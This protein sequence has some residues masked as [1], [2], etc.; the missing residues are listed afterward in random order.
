MIRTYQTRLHLTVE[1]E[2]Q[3]TAYAELYGRVER[4]LFARLAAGDN[5]NHLKQSL[6]KRFGITA[7]QFNAVHSGLKGKIDSIKSRRPELIDDLARRIKRAKQVLKQVAN[8]A[9][10]HQ[11]KRRLAILEHKLAA[12][13]A[14]R[15]SGTVRLCFGSKKLFRS[16]FHLETNGYTDFSAWKRD[17]QSARSSQF[18][19]LGSKDETAGCQG[20]VA[21]VS[22][23]G[24][25]AL[26]LRLPNTAS[27]KHMRLVDLSF[28]HGHDAILAA[29]GRNLSKD[30]D[31]WQAI[32]YRF[33]RDDKGWRV[34]VSVALPEVR[35]I[36]DRR[37]GVIGIDINADH[38]AITETDRFGNPIGS[39]RIPCCTYG[40]SSEQSRAIIGEA[41]KQVIA[42]AIS[43]RK[44][45]AI[46]NLDFRKKKAS[47]EKECPKYARMLSSFAYTQIQTVIRSRAFDKGIEVIEADPTYTSIV[48]QYKYATRYGISAHQ[49]AA[50]A[51]GRNGLGFREAVP[52][53]LAGTLSLPVR[54]RDGHV[55]CSWDMVARKLKA[56]HAAHSRSGKHPRSARLE[57]CSTGSS[58]DV[59]NPSVPG[60]IPECYSSLAPFE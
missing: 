59:I 53:Q 27:A 51:I 57:L 34:F 52:S 26:R 38:L 46:E 30:A 12:L 23:D 21:A 31:D 48:G 54:N 39:T 60:E 29:I 10:C 6:Q 17:W 11:K 55:A 22:E 56:A 9:V 50:L 41:V 28:D 37:L 49:G 24:N 4:T 44:P 14:D 3:I 25:I 40:K 42:M 7:R 47:L 15:S 1:Q 45:V 2:A 8:P 35:Q 32:T 19:V 5:I 18:M 58:S 33:V 16:Q 13:K 36:S 20:C 43:A